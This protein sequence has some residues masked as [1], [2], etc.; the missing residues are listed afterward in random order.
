[1]AEERAALADPAE[2]GRGLHACGELAIGLLLLLHAAGE[3]G[4][5]A[6]PALLPV[7]LSACSEKRWIW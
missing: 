3:S 7:A 5:V 2:D 4:G 1:M 6:R